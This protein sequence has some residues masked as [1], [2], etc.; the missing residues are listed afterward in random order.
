MSTA[1][2]QS[3][4]IEIFPGIWCFTFGQP[5]AI[6]PQSTRHYAPAAESLAPLSLVAEPPV[7]VSATVNDRG[8]LVR[9]PLAAD[10]MIYG[11]GLQLQSF[12]QRASKKKLRV[13]A[14]PVM[15]SGDTHAPVPFYVT[16]RGYGVFIDTARYA[17]FY[18]G[19]KISAPATPRDRLPVTDR[20]DGWNGIP[21]YQQKGYGESSDVWVEI[22][23][24]ARGVNVYVFGG[25]SMR[26]AVQRYNLFSG[27]G[28]IPP[29][30]G[31][32][33]WY[34]AET[35]ASQ[36]DALALAR[37]F[38]ER[39]IPCDVLGLEPHWQSH[40]YS[41]SY[42]W[43]DRFPAP[44]EMLRQLREQ[45][46]RVNVWEQA[47]V[48]PSAAIYRPLLERCGDYEVW[49][50]VVPDFL[51]PKARQIFADYHEQ[52][53]VAAGVSGYKADECDNSDFTGNWSFPE[54]SR[55][56][57]GA[58]GE[59][60]HSLFGLRYQDA[61]QL[62]FEK[63]RQRTFGLVRSSGALAAPYPYVLYSDLYDHRQFVHAVAQSGFSG[64]LWT[65]E[66]RDAAGP[67][68]LIRR[69]QAVALSPLA[70]V[71]AW[72]LKNPPWKQTDK[73]PNNAGEFAERWEQVE[74]QCRAVIEL[75]MQ[76]IPY[77]HAAFV[78]YHREGRPPF[79]A[80]IL[81]YPDDLQAREISD[82]YLIGDA[83]LAAPIVMS[84]RG[85]QTSSA[86][87]P[88]GEARRDVYFP[89]GEWRNFWTGERILGPCHRSV[90]VPLERI[91]LYV[92]SGA[93]LPLARPT[94]H[95]E[96]P[97]SWE[98]TAQVFGDGSLGAEL[99][100]DDGS[101][102]PTLSRIRLTWDAGKSEGKITRQGNV[103]PGA[104]YRVV[105]WKQVR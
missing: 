88:N 65:P 94:L 48:H 7:T 3:T 87:N 83:L 56:P 97:A 30:W 27:G 9:I 53:H 51:D 82:E 17:T 49:G 26:E 57:S 68:D 55:F 46:F 35:N 41:C 80:L 4:P 93:I 71:N 8:V 76:L 72:Y 73:D 91:P 31:L 58:D 15:D 54:T 59:Q 21:P 64:L 36:A 33:F 14:D 79:R 52:A 62:V 60:M 28:P 74:A 24:P 61:L 105:Q 43:S 20:N 99:Y 70:M 67:V 89:T 42:A 25:P 103:A 39:Q 69:L 81:D 16:T 77:L 40:S 10:E 47:F 90:V 96:D 37:E 84:S 5:E 101:Y 78:R 11:L 50:G 66:V 18:L 22:P 100:E 45:G 1:L 34:R 2:T 75:R 23:S 63:R 92:K 98:I 38:R 95:T 104:E 86:I 85:G 12:E 44:S 6:T 29:R 13:N 19:N 102:T 32:G